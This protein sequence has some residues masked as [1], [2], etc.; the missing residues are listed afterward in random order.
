MNV[1]VHMGFM[2]CYPHKAK[3]RVASEVSSLVLLFF[4]FLFLISKFLLIS[5]FCLPILI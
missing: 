2:W 1:G 3:Q 4:S 5:Y